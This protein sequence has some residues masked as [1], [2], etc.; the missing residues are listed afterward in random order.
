M[1]RS[2]VI[3]A[4]DV[5]DADVPCLKQ[6]IDIYN[7]TGCSVIATQVIEGSAISAYG[8]LD[9]KPVAGKW[10]GRLFEVSNL[11]EKPKLDDAPSNL[12][13]IGPLHPYA[14]NL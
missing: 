2:R 6:M 14:G 5:I 4:D 9:A 13:I 12:A 1:N 3:L 10:D 11:V 8:V 7:E